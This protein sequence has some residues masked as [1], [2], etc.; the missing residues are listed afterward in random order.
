MTNGLH[1]AVNFTLPK[2]RAFCY[3][4]FYGFNSYFLTEDLF[5]RVHPTLLPGAERQGGA[6]VRRVKGF[7]GVDWIKNKKTKAYSFSSVVMA[8]R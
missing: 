3:A 8:D 2:R 1:N 6:R 5:V 7:T 4:R